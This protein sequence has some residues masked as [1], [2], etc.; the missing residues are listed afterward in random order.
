VQAG[1]LSAYSS[2][3]LLLIVST[4]DEFE[5]FIYLSFEAKLSL[6]AFREIALAQISL[7]K[8]GLTRQLQN[9]GYIVAPYGGGTN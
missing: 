6:P 5:L 9:Y 3:V 8:R 7:R 2:V 4:R 1:L